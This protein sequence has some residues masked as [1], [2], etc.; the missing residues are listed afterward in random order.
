V[1]D[2][3]S[4]GY[5]G[6]I[7]WALMAMLCYLY[8]VVKVRVTW[9]SPVDEENEDGD[10]AAPQQPLPPPPQPP[11]LIQD[12]NLIWAMAN[13]GAIPPVDVQQAFLQPE[14]PIR[15][16]V[17]DNTVAFAPRGTLGHFY[18]DCSFLRNTP[19][20]KC[21]LHPICARC[22]GQDLE[23]QMQQFPHP[24]PPVQHPHQA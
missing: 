21:K 12:A 20:S 13:A 17:P 14:H 6:M 1:K 10:Q 24:A 9:G 19:R 8:F 11:A 15:D 5:S 18:F 2:S 7:F 3:F 22:Y 16:R 4:L 23:A